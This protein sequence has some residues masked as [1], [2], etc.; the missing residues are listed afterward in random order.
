M[1]AKGF[2]KESEANARGFCGE[3]AAEFYSA[4][5]LKAFLFLLAAWLLSGVSIVLRYNYHN[6]YAQYCGD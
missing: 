1:D 5:P 4:S 3:M 6:C 2:R